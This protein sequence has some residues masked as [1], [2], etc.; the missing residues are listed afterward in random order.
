MFN[1][2]RF[3]EGA[4]SRGKS[5]DRVTHNAG[6]PAAIADIENAE[7][8]IA[9]RLAAIKK[10]K[11]R[12]SRAKQDL[13]KG[14]PVARLSAL[15]AELRAMPQPADMPDV[16]ELAAG[17]ERQLRLLSEASGTSFK[18]QLKTACESQNLN[19]RLVADGVA[20]GPFA[21]VIDPAKENV[22][23]SYAK[24]LF[25]KDL[26]TD[27]AV[28]AKTAAERAGRILEPPNV[29]AVSAQI[30]EAMRVSMARQKKP[31]RGPEFRV[32][33]PAVFREM[34]FIRQ[35]TAGK[36]SSD[37]SLPRFVVELKTLV[38]SNE[39]T[40]GDRRFRL[41]TAVLENAKDPRKSIFIPNDLNVGYGEGSY[42]QA[43]VLIGAS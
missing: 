6:L 3:A 12:L 10:V 13:P 35:T 40:K 16:E 26:P 29:A 1:Q 23:L 42:Y 37:Y 9:S 18:S 38:Q 28:I 41:E 19:F 27:A 7:K 43:I 5:M 2:L 33:L 17:L 36:S 25:I 30:E 4:E 14:K 22:S 15:I 21:L 11:D 32:E 39:N 20:V 24:V 34:S 8:Q 31:S